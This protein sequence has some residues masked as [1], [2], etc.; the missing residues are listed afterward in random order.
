MKRR[1]NFAPCVRLRTTMNTFVAIDV[2]LTFFKENKE[3]DAAAIFCLVHPESGKFFICKLLNGF[4]LV[5]LA[6]FADRY[7]DLGTCGKFYFCD[8]C[9]NAIEP[10]FRECLFSRCWN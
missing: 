1:S 4:M 2:I 3:Q 10:F 6:L 5:R 7:A 8:H 9:C